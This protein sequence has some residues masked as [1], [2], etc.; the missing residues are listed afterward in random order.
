[1]SE[2][3]LNIINRLKQDKKLLFIIILGFAGMLL[4]L[5]SGAGG[6][7]P[8][9]TNKNEADVFAIQN[10]TE[11]KLEMLLES[12]KGAGKVKVMVT[13]DSLEETIYAVNTET[14][15][16]A[17]EYSFSD[18]YVLIE[19]SGDDDGLIIKVTAPVIRG[20][21]I[22]CEGADSAGV[23]EEIIRLVSAALGISVNRI[24]VTVMQN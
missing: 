3:K 13:V 12:V 19:K 8:A 23:K 22:T 10:K 9:E 6:E 21:G 2:I 18:E 4:I 15:S 5:L 16:R 11:K 7:K 20:V 17:D 14:E 24:W 1:M